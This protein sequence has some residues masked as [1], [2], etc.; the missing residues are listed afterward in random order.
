M[1]DIAV[2]TLRAIRQDGRTLEAA[3][4]TATERGDLTQRDRGLARAI[5]LLSL[6]HYHSLGAVLES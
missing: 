1:R 5:I 6:R 4:L 3:F 2:E